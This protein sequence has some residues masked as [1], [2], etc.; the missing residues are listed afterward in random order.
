MNNQ[1]PQTKPDT[2]ETVLASLKETNLILSEKFA[3][4]DRILS[5]KLSRT[6][7]MIHEN[8]SNAE[9][10]F[11]K[12]EY[13][14]DMVWKEIRET[15]K[16]VKENSKLIGGMGNS[17]GDVAESYFRNS[18]AKRMSFAGQKYDSISQNLSRKVRKLNLQD[19]YDLVLYNCTSV[20]IIEIKYKADKDDIEDLLKKAL[21]FKKLFPEYAN[22]ELYLGLAGFSVNKRVEK[23]AVKQGIAVIKQVGD[24]MV[25]NDKN[26]K[27]F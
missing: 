1:T 2:F 15:Q 13:L 14:K 25:I 4:T 16:I 9:E 7:K 6:E 19:E 22:F 17:N 10:R 26:L 21:T 24:T 11:Q 12:L 23:E 27:V 8:A 20:A 5:E 3:E 18:F